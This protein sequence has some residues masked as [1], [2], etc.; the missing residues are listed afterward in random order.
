MKTDCTRSHR[1]ILI[2]LIIISAWSSVFSQ[3]IE[4]SK[5]REINNFF[6]QKQEF[7][8]IKSDESL[9]SASRKIEAVG[10]F[11]GVLLEEKSYSDLFPKSVYTWKNWRRDQLG[12]E[13]ENDKN[14][15]IQR[16]GFR[17]K[18]ALIQTGVMLGVQHGFR[19][20]QLKTRRELGGAFFRD[21]GESVKS[22]RGWRDGD[23]LFTNYMAHPLQGGVSARIFVTN[24]PEASRVEFGSSKKYWKSRLEAFTWAAFWSTQFELG[25][26]SEASIGNVGVYKQNGYSSM[27]WV[28]MVI[29]PTLGTGILIGEDMIERFV[30]KKWL[31][32]YDGKLP[33]KYKL[34]RSLLTPTISINNLFRGKLPWQRDERVFSVSN[35]DE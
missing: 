14:K 9:I 17:L 11:S 33:L 29:T 5:K 25:P 26:V 24:S 3:K 31:R 1:M 16:S 21:W 20:L 12:G 19:L 23:S 35:P 4:F 10:K 2:I 28:D 34:M 18:S 6:G 27:A 13:E 8:P 7:R 15:P 22:L 32:K 30:I